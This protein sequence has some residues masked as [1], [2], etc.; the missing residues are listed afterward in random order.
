MLIEAG[1]KIGSELM[2]VPDGKKAKV[3]DLKNKI[4]FKGGTYTTTGFCKKFMPDER[5][6]AKDAYQGPKYFTFKGELLTDLRE[7]FGK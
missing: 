2:F 1:V 3:A 6:N 4:E 7:K 5:R